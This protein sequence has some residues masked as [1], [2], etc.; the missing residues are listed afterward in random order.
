M[1]SLDGQVASPFYHNLH[2]A[3]MQAMYILTGEEVFKEYATLWL[4][5]QR[6]FIYKSLAFIQKSAQKILE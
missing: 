5:R 6:N 3:Q 4:K 2:I 1:Y